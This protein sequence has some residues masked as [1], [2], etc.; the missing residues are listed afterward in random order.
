MDRA[1]VP[2]YAPLHDAGPARYPSE[3]SVESFDEAILVPGTRRWSLT[4]DVA[5]EEWSGTPT[6][7]SAPRWT[8]PRVPTRLRNVS[9]PVMM[10]RGYSDGRV[11]SLSTA[12]ELGSTRSMSRIRNLVQP[13]RASSSM[14]DERGTPPFQMKLGTR[15][16]PVSSLAMSDS[17]ASG[18]PIGLWTA[19]ASNEY[20]PAVASPESDQHEDDDKEESTALVA[21][22]E[23]LQEENE[24]MEPIYTNGVSAP[25]IAETDSNKAAEEQTQDPENSL[26][27]PCASDAIVL[28]AADGAQ[29][30]MPAE[31]SG[32]HVTANS[33]APAPWSAPEAQT[34]HGALP[35]LLGLQTL[36]MLGGAVVN[37]R[38]A[39]PASSLGTSLPTRS[40]LVL[41]TRPVTSLGTR[42]PEPEAAEPPMDLASAAARLPEPAAQNTTFRPAPL[43]KSQGSVRKIPSVPAI[44]TTPPRRLRGYLAHTCLGAK[45]RFRPRA[46]AVYWA[47]LR[48]GSLRLYE[49][50]QGPYK[51]EASDE[52]AVKH[53]ALVHTLAKPVPVVTPGMHHAFDLILADSTVH[54]F[55]ASDD[56]EARRWAELC[57]LY[58]AEQ[59]CIPQP[60]EPSHANFGW[61]GVGRAPP[62]SLAPRK[63][64]RALVHL[65][66]SIRS[67]PREQL[68]EWV[69]P[70]VPLWPSD[71]EPRQQCTQLAQHKANLEQALSEHTQVRQAMLELWGSNAAARE[72]A[73]GN[74][75]RRC[76]YLTHELHKFSTYHTTLA[77]ALAGARSVRTDP[78]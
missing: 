9:S 74:W 22:K 35:P 57:N 32:A 26:L 38:S 41:K 58:A 76:A 34:V 17:S 3:M 10:E 30:A 1:S 29:A 78:M 11:S 8:R 33:D 4:P 13:R 18:T 7:E 15:R 54:R 49:T 47:E 50:D 51:D 45:R 65:F 73:L 25:I 37:D 6:S 48:N 40:S 64:W 55:Q 42:A 12:P 14:S 71:H 68:S 70:S 69:V 72:K 16:R 75:D 67:E 77:H 27:P 23:V 63:P 2:N 19:P 43:P 52:G 53:Y 28:P 44:A 46:A 20:F 62:P 56:G 36:P 31:V 60:D 21:S 5:Q 61:K 59:S 66:R 24:T 39:R